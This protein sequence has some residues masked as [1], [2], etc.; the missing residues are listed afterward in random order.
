[1]PKKSLFLLKK[2]KKITLFFC[3]ASIVTGYAQI[4]QEH[5]YVTNDRPSLNNSFP[6]DDGY[7]D[8]Y[9]VNGPYNGPY[10]LDLF[11]G[12]THVLYKSM[13]MPPSYTGF[14]NNSL[15]YKDNQLPQYFISK[16]LFNDDDLIEFITPV[17]Y[18]NPFGNGISAPKLIISNE[19]GTI[20]YEIF[21]RY[22]PRLVKTGNDQY[23]LL[24][25]M[26]HNGQYSD[27]I[28]S[29]SIQIDV[30]S[31]P[32]TLNL[33]QQEIYLAREAFQGHPNPTSN[34]ITISNS[35]PLPENAELEVFDMSGNRIQSQTVASGTID[36]IVDTS[37]LSTG[38]YVYKING[39]TGKFIK[40]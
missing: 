31:L 25:S 12:E 37:Q 22:A 35:Q 27:I 34:R 15:I 38:V 14:A 26:G 1:M 21:D 13:P 3:I 29:G 8:F 39:M 23:K 11:D 30:Y 24:V 5:T 32:G 17:Q 20:L 9:L 6:G 18:Y 10:T 33:G 19:Q 28:G 4:F 2:M 40:K 36:I 7:M 16:H